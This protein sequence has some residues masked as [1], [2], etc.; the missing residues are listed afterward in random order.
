MRYSICAALFSAGMIQP[1]FF[2]LLSKQGDIGD[3]YG[4][5]ATV[6]GPT[7]TPI[8]PLYPTLFCAAYRTH[9]RF[10]ADGLGARM[11]YGSGPECHTRSK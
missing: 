6:L 11:P 5:L 3:N 2:Q 9:Y 1:P 8:L 10:K 4:G 7:P